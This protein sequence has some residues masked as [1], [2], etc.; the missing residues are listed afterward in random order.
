MD[1]RIEEFHKKLYADLNHNKLTI[2]NH[3]ILLH[4]KFINISYI[5]NDNI[6]WFNISMN[7]TI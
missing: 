6:L 5:M 4:S 3:I 7:Y 2:Q 1:Q